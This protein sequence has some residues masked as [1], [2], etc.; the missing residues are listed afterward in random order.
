MMTPSTTDVICEPT[1][2]Y[3]QAGTYL[4]ALLNVTEYMFEGEQLIANTVDDQRLLTFN[5]ARPMP[6]PGTVWALKFWWQKDD[7]QWS[8]VIPLSTSTMIFGDDGTAN[9]SGGCN[10]FTVS[11]TGDLQVEK[12]MEATD[13]YA[14]LPALTFG[15]VSAQMAACEEPEGIMQQEQGFFISLGSTAYYFKLGGVLLLLDA[16]GMPLL[17]FAAQE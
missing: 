7:E 16:K 6:M 9:G 8:P 12:V 4:S 1:E 15:P 13:T 5:P 10:D 14:E 11:Y 17:M 2:L 3:S